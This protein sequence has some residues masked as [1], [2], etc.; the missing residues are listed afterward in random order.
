MASAGS[1]EHVPGKGLLSLWPGPYAVFSSASAAGYCHL[2]DMVVSGPFAQTL[3]EWSSEFLIVLGISAARNRCL[4]PL[5]EE[6]SDFH[7]SLSNSL[8]MDIVLGALLDLSLG[9]IN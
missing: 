3:Q 7:E 8:S 1:L 5:S 2:L 9:G 6:V 4:T